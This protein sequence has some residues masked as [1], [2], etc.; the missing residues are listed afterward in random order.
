MKDFIKKS[1]KELVT[2]LSQKREAVRVFRFNVSGSN[3]RNVKEGSSLQ[4][5][6]A[7]ILTLLNKPKVQAT[8]ETK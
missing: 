5:D 3:T 8:T 4:K 1:N 7:R 6:I 2:L